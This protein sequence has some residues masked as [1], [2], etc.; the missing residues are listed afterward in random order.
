MES[1]STKATF[2]GRFRN[3]RELFK[4]NG[5]SP[6]KG[7]QLGTPRG[8]PPIQN[9]PRFS[10]EYEEIGRCGSHFVLTDSTQYLRRH[11]ETVQIMSDSFA[12]RRLTIDIQLPSDPDLGFDGGGDERIFWIPVTSI[13]KSPPR[14]NIDLRDNRGTAL[15]LLTRYENGLIS[16]AAL[17]D[18]AAKLLE[19]EPSS[20]FKELLRETVER[21]K[22]AGQVSCALAEA[23]CRDANV[24]M[25]HESAKAFA[26]TLRV[27]AGNAWVWVPLQGRR[28]ERRVIKFHYD[29]EFDRPELFRQRPKTHRY[30]IAAGN[31]KVA[32]P[33]QLR[34]QG[35]GNPY[36]PPRRLATRLASATGLASVNLGI[37]SRPYLISSTSYHLQVES[38]PGVETRD[39][40][41]FADVPSK[42]DTDNVRRSHG[43]H[44]YVNPVRLKAEGAGLALVTL[45]VGRRG[46]MTLSWLSAVLSV[47][48]LWLFDLTSRTHIES[49]EATV[50][51]ILF[52]PALLAALVVRPGE[53]PVATKLFSGVRLLVAMNGILAVAAAAAVADVRPEGWS[54]EHAWFIY[55]ITASVIAV[56]ISF[57]WVL[58]WDSTFRVV[59]AMR[60]ELRDVTKYRRISATIVGLTGLV[61]LFGGLDI[62]LL[63]ADGV[64]VAVL[65][66]LVVAAGFVSAS[67]ARLRRSAA[68]LAWVCVSVAV[69]AGVFADCDLVMGLAARWNWRSIWLALSA[70]AFLAFVTL[71]IQDVIRRRS[72]MDRDFDLP[73]EDE[74]SRSRPLSIGELTPSAERVRHQARE[75]GT[76]TPDLLAPSAS[77]EDETPPE[78]FKA[79]LKMYAALVAGN[80]NAMAVEDSETEDIG[81]RPIRIIDKDD[82]ER[83]AADSGRELVFLG[84]V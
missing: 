53:H 29:I 7:L 12:R 35:D 27:L 45:R 72:G 40:D 20:L 14:S 8:S 11:V 34:E 32:V 73:E 66:C 54:I 44:L 74:G 80:A 25:E 69:L 2:R 51:V 59:S 13:T 37:K 17:V 15:A 62:K 33:L 3:A 65:T 67:Y 9:D 56:I 79:A 36:S 77:R 5:K 10:L 1:T 76:G 64:Y 61:F 55:A 63:E 75:A 42:E 41:L 84:N 60:E 30:L 23:A 28:S 71:A 47:A 18:A 38:P 19:K 81:D 22:I 48:L 52:G 57:S 26:E 58:S 70:G 68:R 39:I 31:T 16:H 6:L 24:D 46:F 43:I 21:D 4:S 78:L 82:A 49:R 50:T 83:R